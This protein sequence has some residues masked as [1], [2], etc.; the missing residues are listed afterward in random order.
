MK[1]NDS[2]HCLVY[3]YAFEMKIKTHDPYKF[4]VR[5]MVTI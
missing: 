4:K 5:T 2:M 1:R 3:G